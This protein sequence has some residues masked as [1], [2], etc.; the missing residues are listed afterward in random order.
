VSDT[1]S[2]SFVST[3]NAY[4]GTERSET[5]S[6]EQSALSFLADGA[7]NQISTCT[8]VQVKKVTNT[9]G[10][11]AEV[12]RV[13]VLPLVNQLDGYGNA[14]AH[15][16]VYGVPY[17]RYQGGG[18]AIILDPKV[19]DV[20]LMVSADRDISNVKQT[21]KQ[22]N[23]GSRRKYDLADGIYIGLCLGGGDPDQYIRFTDDQ[24]EIRGKGGKR[25]VISATTV[26]LNP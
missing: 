15:Q 14:V 1:G 19:G 7:V 5:S 18:N 3:N 22:A 8:L 12:G 23:P 26:A 4:L 24:V 6:N 20:G 25:I 10:Q 17:Y 13:D 16:V 9:P 21:K 2:S 11:L